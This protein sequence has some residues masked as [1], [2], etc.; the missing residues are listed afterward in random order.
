MWLTCASTDIH[1][2]RG[3]NGFFDHRDRRIIIYVAIGAYF[4]AGVSY[5]VG[6]VRLSIA[7]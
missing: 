1:G 3:A 2:N 7:G 6:G 4:M 5:A